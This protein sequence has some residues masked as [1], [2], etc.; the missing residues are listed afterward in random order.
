M[1]AKSLILNSNNLDVALTCNSYTRELK[2]ATIQYATTTTIT[3][4]KGATRLIT[5]Y[6]IAKNLSITY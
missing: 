3:N 2:L 1:H 6:A 5:V 4:K